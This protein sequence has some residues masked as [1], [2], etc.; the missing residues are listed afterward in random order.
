MNYHKIE[1]FSTNNGNGIRVVLWVSGCSLNCK[2]C[3]NPETH[4]PNAGKLWTQE[5]EQELFESLDKDYISGITFSGGH[6]LEHY[7]IDI[8][9]ELS[10]KI[11][12]KFPNKSQW[13]YT[14]YLWE[15][16]KDLEIM[17]YLDV[18]V[19]GPYIDE[20]RDISLKW[21]GSLNQRVINIPQSI[22]ENKVILFCD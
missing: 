3:Q 8:I 18:I 1:K 6:P 14:G 5:S 4:D 2:N 7:N 11:K 15:N 10:K 9:T 20:L 16:I 13:L 22:K 19:D 12:Q 21:R 17:K